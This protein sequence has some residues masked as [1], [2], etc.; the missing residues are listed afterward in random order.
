MKPQM[1]SQ[2]NTDGKEMGYLAMRSSSTNSYQCS[3]LDL[4]GGKNLGM[5]LMTMEPQMTAR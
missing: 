2:M 1:G 4:I 3:S 5:E